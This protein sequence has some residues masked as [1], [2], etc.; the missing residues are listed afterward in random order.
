MGSP[1]PALPPAAPCAA[2]AEPSELLKALQAGRGAAEEAARG[3]CKRCGQ[4][5]HMAFQCR[6]FLQLGGAARREAAPA[7]VDSLSSLSDGGEVDGVDSDAA[8]G[9]C[10]MKPSSGP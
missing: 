1:R 10:A 6:N 5:G 9:G 3:A 2:M 8:G 7:P 4:V